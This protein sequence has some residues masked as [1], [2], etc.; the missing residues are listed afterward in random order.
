MTAILR[1]AT[2]ALTLL[3]LLF[4][5]TACP[6]PEAPPEGDA[7][8]T[9]T[10]V[11][12][13][14]YRCEETGVVYGRLPD[15]YLPGRMSTRPYAVYESGSTRDV[16]F[17]LGE[18]SANKYLVLA[19]EKT[20]Y[21]YNFIVAEGYEMPT[22]PEMDPSEVWICQDAER[23]WTDANV[24]SKMRIGERVNLVVA[25]WR[26]GEAATLPFATPEVRVQLIF[27]SEIYTEFYYYCTY[28]SFGEGECYLYESATERCVRVPDDLFEGYKLSYDD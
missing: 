7:P 20:Y 10:R 26:D 19:D 1:R 18:E 6:T 4:S 27:R 12:A 21:P 28:Y 11:E 3:L 9:L 14:V 2:A 15:T 22:L 8:L 25:A 24:V 23:F 13:G 5:L 17:R 16:Y